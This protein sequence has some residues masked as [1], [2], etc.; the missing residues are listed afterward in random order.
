M[1]V[2]PPTDLYLGSKVV[3][4]LVEFIYFFEST[5]QPAVMWDDGGKVV[6]KYVDRPTFSLFLPL[7]KAHSNVHRLK[8]PKAQMCIV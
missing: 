1:A 8:K 4:D 3:D 6:R 7:G 2:N 5:C